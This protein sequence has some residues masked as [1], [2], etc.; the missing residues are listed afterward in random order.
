MRFFV[1]SKLPAATNKSGERDS[2]Q[3]DLNCVSL[4]ARN[5]DSIMTE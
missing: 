2:F 1:H 4:S 5:Y 3:L